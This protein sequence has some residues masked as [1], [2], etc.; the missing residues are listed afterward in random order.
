[1]TLQLE[2][3]FL[4][5]CGRFFLIITLDGHLIKHFNLSDST[6]KHSFNISEIVVEDN[7]NLYARSLF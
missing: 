4:K 7:Q 6:G 2:N 3:L 1:M 5:E